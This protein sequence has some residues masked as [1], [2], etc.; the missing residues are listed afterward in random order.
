M[1][2]SATASDV[3][4]WRGVRVEWEGKRMSLVGRKAMER[5]GG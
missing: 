2:V 1:V 3:T 4:G 5:D